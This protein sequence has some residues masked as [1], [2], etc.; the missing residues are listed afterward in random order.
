MKINRIYLPRIGDMSVIVIVQNDL[1]F[2]ILIKI[3]EH[4]AVSFKE[5]NRH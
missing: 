2:K 5:T 4:F 1:I 3:S